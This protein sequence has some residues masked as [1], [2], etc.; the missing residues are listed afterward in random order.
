MT[1]SPNCN[2]PKDRFA[3]A[4]PLGDGVTTPGTV[5]FIGIGGIGMSGLARMYLA[6]GYAV[7]GSDVQRSANLDALECAGAK[8]LIGHDPGHVAGADLVVYSSSISENHPER[9][10]AKNKGARLIHRSEALAEICRG[11]FTIAVTGTHGKTTTT[12]LVGMILQGAGRDP[13]IVVGGVVNSFGGNACFGQG[14]E[15]VIEAD[16]SDSSFLNFSPSIEVITNIEAEH[17][18]HFGT[19]ARVEGAYRDFIRR[20]PEGGEWLGC[21]E[22]PQVLKIAALG[23]RRAVLYGFDPERS[24]LVA[25]DIVECENGERGIA[26]KVWKKNDCLGLVKLRI[27]GR[28]NV[29][30]ALAAI[31]VGLK[32]GVSFDS[33]AGS[34]ERFEGARR[35]FDVKYED[36]KFLVVD[37]YAHH[38]TEIRQTLMAAKGLH[39]TR[40][41]ALFQPHRYTRTQALLAEF[42]ESFRAADRLIVTDIYAASEKPIPGVSGENVC[43][44]VKNAGHPNVSFVERSR[45]T[46]VL[47]KEVRCGDLVIA[48]GAG[49]IFEVATELS[50]RLKQELFSGKLRGK[51]LL[52]EPLSRHTS[53]KIGG[54]S[55]FWVEPEDEEDL[56]V[57]LSIC[58]EHGLKITV[59]GSGSNVLAPDPG[60]K[61]VVIQLNS[62]Y[63]RKVWEENGKLAARAGVPNTL[64]IQYAW[65]RGLGGAEFLSGIPGCVGGTVAMNAGSHGQ[66]VDALIETV[67]V[68]CFS[69]QRRTFK[70]DEIG[71]NYRTS[72][73][74]DCVITEARF[75]L[76][77]RD[78]A[79]T[80]KI[81]D[82]Y[83]ATRAKSQDLRHASAGCMFKNPRH[84]GCSSGQLIEEAGL[85]G[86]SVGRAQV[87]ATHA[88][89][90]IN[91]GGATS[92]DVLALIEEVRKTVR[93]KFSVELETEVKIL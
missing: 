92:G 70:K 51:V 53:L 14:P 1:P 5:H 62:P 56:R 24:E 34:L 26:F 64:F 43:R 38:P 89:F 71:F 57:A 61:G 2:D 18:D 77:K 90:I 88:N 79:Q 37:D 12:A 93:E 85:K 63:F 80:Q 3:S 44:A 67:S 39:R 87:S 91:L 29:L 15:I 27:I 84:G 32:R 10:A 49:D 75:T 7:Q 21:S 19:M 46:D 59:L 28:H 13:S 31:G 17:M 50:D 52:N 30:N 69:G 54:P 74:R 25:T 8:I 33:I 58:R 47:L 11:K 35:R 48:L 4:N 55:E 81:L 42:G 40:I 76:P 65:E 45:I 41:V 22:D 78:P 20:L 6:G 83:R 60:L 72:G 68:V 82:E 86:R 9:L 16:E 66:S 36:S 73:L 23:I